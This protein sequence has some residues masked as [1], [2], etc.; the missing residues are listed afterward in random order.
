[1][2]V[3]ELEGLP[4]EAIVRIKQLTNILKKDKGVA[5]RMIDE[6]IDEINWDIAFSNS[7]DVF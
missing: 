6:L 2:E 1:M 3:I 5:L 4:I 7:Q